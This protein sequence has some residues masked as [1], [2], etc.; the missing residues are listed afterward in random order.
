V[1]L[2]SRSGRQVSIINPATGTATAINI[3]NAADSDFGLGVAFG[4]G[5]TIYG[6]V[7][8]RPLRRAS[9]DVASG[10]GTV[11]NSFTNA[12]I[13]AAPIAVS[14]DGQLL[15]AIAIESVDNVQLYSIADANSDPTFLDFEFFSTPTD[16]PNGNAVGA[17]DF[18]AGMLFALD[19]NNGIL[20]LNVRAPAAGGPRLNAAREGNELVL[21]WSGN[22]RLM[23]SPTVDGPFSE[24]VGATSG[25]RVN[26]LSGMSGFYQLRVQ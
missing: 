6:K 16:I 9:I 13:N 7:N 22:A 12:A 10:T 8:G 11:L 5:N 1:L 19:T 26:L 3:T 20:G 15:A 25:H 21:T 14:P 24:V 18:G 17:L 23:Y 2:G 4:P